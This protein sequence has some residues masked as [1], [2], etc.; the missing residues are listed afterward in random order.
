[1]CGAISVV[2]GSFGEI[3]NTFRYEENPPWVFAESWDE[4]AKICKDLLN[5]KDHLQEVQNNLLSWWNNRIDKIQDRVNNVFSNIE[6]NDYSYKLKNFPPINFISVDKSEDRRNLLYEK[7]ANYNLTNIRP[8]IFEVYNDEDHHY[9][10]ESFRELNGIGRG[11]TTSHLKAI[12]D[13]YFDTEEEYAFFCEDDI[14]F[15]TVKYWNFTWEEF[16]N[17]PSAFSVSVLVTDELI[18]ND[19]SVD[20]SVSGA[21]APYSFSW[22]NGATTEDIAGLDSGDYVFIISDANG[23]TYSDTVTVLSSTVGINNQI[24]EINWTI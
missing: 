7:F 13:W 10:G 14:S 6:Y 1:M 22:G 24:G 11:P 20:L 9:I 23:C 12:K 18:G 8:H 21:T 16:F 3:E 5:N 2:V 4:A 15:D 19:G 17:E